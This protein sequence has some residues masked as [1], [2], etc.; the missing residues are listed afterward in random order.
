[1]ASVAMVRKVYFDTDCLSSFY[2]VEKFDILQA[3]YQGRIVIPESVAHEISKVPYLK[4][5][6]KRNL[7]DNLITVDSLTV[8]DRIT[9]DYY[10]E[11]TSIDP[12]MGSGEAE[13]LLL[14]KQNQG[15]LASNNLRDISRYVK[16]FDMQHLTTPRILMKA[17]QQNI[18]TRNDC[19]TIWVKMLERRIKLPYQTYE[20]YRDKKNKNK[21]Y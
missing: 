13:A 8:Y 4:E 1:M 2:W 15:I 19:D 14:A 18:I 11:L 7:D 21:T 6:H 10:N 3:L 20:E 17:E 9:R 16:L 12:K 5:E